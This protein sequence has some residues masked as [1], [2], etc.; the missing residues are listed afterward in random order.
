MNILE[1]PKLAKVALPV[2]RAIG[3]IPWIRLGARRRIV[4]A[5][6][7]A[8]SSPDIPFEVEYHGTRYRGSI[9][10]AQE[11]HVYF[12]GGYELKEVAAIRDLLSAMNGPVVYDI[13]GNLG[14]HTLAMAGLAST[15][16]TFEPFGP[17]AKTVAERLE[18]NGL[19]HVTLHTVGLGENAETRPYFLDQESA[20]SGTGSFLADHAGAP[21]AAQLTIARGDDLISSWGPTA[22]PPDFVK[23]DIEGYE[24]PALMGL[25]HTMTESPPIIMMEITESS[26]RIFSKYGGIEHVLPFEF[27]VYRIK[28]PQNKLGLFTKS[29]Y[30]LEKISEVVAQK[31]SYNVFIVPKVR[32]NWFE[33]L[34]Q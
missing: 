24:A 10:V 19:D 7:P 9:A 21:E 33:T 32:S 26:Q 2:L 20:N 18:L 34:T 3:R 31:S 27:D 22:A 28:N 11:W 13:G 29:S 14:G 4:S 23:I 1:K 25:R 5:L 8:D 12:F 16:H 17:L 30:F 15:I 6:F